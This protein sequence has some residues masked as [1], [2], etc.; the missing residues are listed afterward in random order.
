MEPQE[1]NQGAQGPSE[2][3]VSEEKAHSDLEK[4]H[5]KR[6]GDFW[7]STAS[8]SPFSATRGHRVS[9]FGDSSDSKARGWFL[10]VCGRY[11]ELLSPQSHQRG[12]LTDCLPI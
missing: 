10:S 2:G 8:G 7:L 12:K 9:G 4:V 11:Q 6:S 5:G 3:K 1:L